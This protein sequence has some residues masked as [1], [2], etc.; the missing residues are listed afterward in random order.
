MLVWSKWFDIDNLASIDRKPGVYKIRLKSLG[1]HRPVLISRLL[2]KDKDGLL[3]I[4]H[5]VNLRDRIQN[6]RRV[7]KDMTGFCKHSA[8][9]R[10]FLARICAHS[11]SNTYFNDKN[12]QVSFASLNSKTEAKEQEER[13]L[14]CYFKKYGEL[15]PLNNS[16]PDENVKLWNEILLSKCE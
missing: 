16:M 13:L 14:K 9:D 7:A 3:S 8:G 6:F 4:G 10:L 15:P 2:G 12:I 5:S 11:S 1:N